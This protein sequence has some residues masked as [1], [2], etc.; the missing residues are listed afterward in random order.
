M[1]GA[2]TGKAPLAKQPSAKFSLLPRLTRTADKAGMDHDITALGDVATGGLLARAAEPE[3]G[4]GQGADQQDREQCL[5]CEAPLHGKHC[6]HCGQSTHV[7]RSISTFWHDLLHSVLHFEGKFW[8][9]LPLLVFR[10]G[11]LTRRYVYGQRARF[12]SPLARF[13]FTVF[14]MF[15]TFSWIGG[16][17]KGEDFT[18]LDG[19][20]LSKE[21]LQDR[22]RLRTG[23][24]NAIKGEVKASGEEAD[25]PTMGKIAA[26]EGELQGLKASEGMAKQFDVK[27]MKSGV[28]KINTG[29][30]DF[31]AKLKHALSNPQLLL[32]KMQ[33]SAYKYSWLLIP[34]SLPFVWLMFAWRREV[35]PYDHLVFITYSLS[36]MTILLVAY[37]VVNKV[38][39]LDT[40]STFMLVLGVPLHMFAQLRGAYQLSVSSAVL[41]TVM[42]LVSSFVV[43]LLFAAALLWMGIS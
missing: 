32:Y 9:T 39:A 30:P 25:G 14:L 35:R 33:S 29:N 10:P 41:R 7:H 1:A 18:A 4:E 36:F 34:M 20:A 27:D 6:H 38:P 42:L 23:E 11:Q 19:I 13:L 26:L 3:A 28:N 24:L 16:P 2:I 40:V 12:I 22:I 15:A 21:Q 37:T 31:D 17:V 5:N 43:M 8:H